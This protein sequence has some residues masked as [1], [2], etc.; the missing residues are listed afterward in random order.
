MMCHEVISTLF[1]CL[2]AKEPKSQG[3]N[4]FC[5]KLSMSAKRFE[6]AALK[7]QIVLDA[8]MNNLLNATKF[9]ALASLCRNKYRKC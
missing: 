8:S 1:F 6:L 7:Q 9:K 5:Y 4:F 3:S 2:D